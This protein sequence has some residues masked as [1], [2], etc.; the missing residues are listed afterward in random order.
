[1]LSERQQLEKRHIT[2]LLHSY[3]FKT[4]QTPTIF[5]DTNISDYITKRGKNQ[6]KDR[7]CPGE[8]AESVPSGR[9]SWREQGFRKAGPL[10]WSGR[11]LPEGSLYNDSLKWTQVVCLL[12]YVHITTKENWKTKPHT[13]LPYEVRSSVA[14]SH[15]ENPDYNQENEL[16]LY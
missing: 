4:R 9:G 14:S 7:S 1:M 12:L 5:Q 6:T 11:R 8:R 16:F 15:L 13:N 2:L 3:K 10:C